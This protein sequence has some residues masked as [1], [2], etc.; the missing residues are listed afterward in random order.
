M[1]ICGGAITSCKGGV[2]P[3]EKANVKTW[4]KKKK[5]FEEMGGEKK[6]KMGARKTYPVVK[7]HEIA[8]GTEK[9]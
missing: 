9:G 4:G 5:I 2:C 1:D 3:Q 8:R 6:N 7:E